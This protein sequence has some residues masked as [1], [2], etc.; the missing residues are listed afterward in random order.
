MVRR[1]YSLRNRYLHS[2]AWTPTSGTGWNLAITNY[3][4]HTVYI[5]Y[6][7]CGDRFFYSWVPT[8]TLDRGRHLRNAL[9]T[10]LWDN[11]CIRNW[12]LS[13]PFRCNG[14]VLLG[15]GQAS[16]TEQLHMQMQASLISETQ[17]TWFFLL[18]LCVRKFLFSDVWGARRLSARKDESTF[19]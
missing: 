5:L 17:T 9:G 7:S 2:C 12:H 10:Y 13:Y 18:C 16:G 6:S 4:L 8:R 14:E 1:I 11:S 3:S 15:W 19:T